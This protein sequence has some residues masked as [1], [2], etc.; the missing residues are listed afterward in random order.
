MKGIL[1]IY[2]P[3]IFPDEINLIVRTQLYGQHIASIWNITRNTYFIK[4][5]ISHSWNYTN[6]YKAKAEFIIMLIS[7]EIRLKDTNFPIRI[8]QKNIHIE[9]FFYKNYVSVKPPWIISWSAKR[10]NAFEE[11][12]A[13][14]CRRHLQMCICNFVIF[15]SFFRN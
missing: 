13:S 6:W 2:N 15:F 8:Y 9:R 3:I 14:F 4:S 7:H 12:L 10:Q 5:M 11:Y 1:Y